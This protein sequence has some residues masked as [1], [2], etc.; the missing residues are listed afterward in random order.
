MRKDTKHFGEKLQTG[1]IFYLFFTL[2]STLR[3]LKISAD[4]IDSAEFFKYLESENIFVKAFGESNKILK[5]YLYSRE[6]QNNNYHFVEM[7]ID[8]NT[9]ELNTFFFFKFFATSPPIGWGF[10][11][12]K[13]SLSCFLILIPGWLSDIHS[14]FSIHHSHLRILIPGWLSDF[15]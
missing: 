11:I 10:I 7:T 3:S 12:V 6:T 13:F 5:M 2:N 8:F 9:L 4:E 15:C 1:K 14:Y